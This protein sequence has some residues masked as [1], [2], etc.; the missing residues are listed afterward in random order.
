MTSQYLSTDRLKELYE[1]G[2]LMRDPRLLTKDKQNSSI[3][4]DVQDEDNTVVCPNF[5][6]FRLDKRGIFFRKLVTYLRLHRTERASYVHGT[7]YLKE[8]IRYRRGEVTLAAQ[9]AIHLGTPSSKVL[10]ILHNELQFQRTSELERA[11]CASTRKRGDNDHTARKR[12]INEDHGQPPSKKPKLSEK[13]SSSSNTQIDTIVLEDDD[14]PGMHEKDISDTSLTQKANHSFTADELTVVEDL[15]K[16]QKRRLQWLLDQNLLG[17]KYFKYLKREDLSFITKESLTMQRLWVLFAKDWLIRDPAFLF[18]KKSKQNAPVHRTNFSSDIYSKGSMISHSK[19]CQR[20]YEY[21]NMTPESRANNLSGIR[22]YL[23]EYTP[24]RF[25]EVVC[26][27]KYAL[28]NKHVW[29]EI[30][31]VLLYGGLMPHLADLEIEVF[32]FVQPVTERATTCPAEIIPTVTEENVAEYTR[33]QLGSNSMYTL[34][35]E[36][37]SPNSKYYSFVEIEDVGSEECSFDRSLYSKPYFVKPC[38]RKVTQD[39]LQVIPLIAYPVYATEES[40]LHLNETQKDRIRWLLKQNLLGKKCYTYLK[41]GHWKY[42]AAE[43]F[44][45]FRLWRLYGLKKIIRDPGFLFEKD[46]RLAK[47][48]ALVHTQGCFD[49]VDQYCLHHRRDQFFKR[50]RRYLMD[51]RTK[52]LRNYVLDY[53]PYRYDV[54]VAAVKSISQ[55]LPEFPLSR[56]S[57]MLKQGRLIRNAHQFESDVNKL[58]THIKSCNICNSINCREANTMIK[59]KRLSTGLELEDISDEE[60]SM[61]TMTRNKSVLTGIDLE[62][63]SDEESPILLKEIADTPVA[64]PTPP[65]AQETEVVVISDDEETVPTNSNKSFASDASGPLNIFGTRRKRAT[66]KLSVTSTLLSKMGL[67]I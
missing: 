2:Y 27:V 36:T 25:N 55:S 40:Q 1:Q 39:K 48:K 35:E 64:I 17:K 6:D 26:T 14:E 29:D 7:K 67:K 15:E 24:Y 11:L 18:P 43:T 46:I 28:A 51:L 63:I 44:S 30:S 32:G 37:S 53:A 33:T 3:T 66:K 12:S 42:L 65:S 56:I 10:D 62:E 5:R 13:S 45:M 38:R 61:L 4:H 22:D 34:V 49:P 21:L 20:L 23:V 60:S 8:Y 41:P 19:Y 16:N 31:A 9:Y 50:L 58:Q 59:R 57:A 52:K 54:I 47:Q